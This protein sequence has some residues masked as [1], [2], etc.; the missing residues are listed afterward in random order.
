MILCD[1]V[2]AFRDVM[3]HYLECQNISRPRG[4]RRFSS[5]CAHLKLFHR[6]FIDSLKEIV[7]LRHLNG[8]FF[9][10]NG[11]PPSYLLYDKNFFEFTLHSNQKLAS[12]PWK[13]F[14]PFSYFL[15]PSFQPRLF[16]ISRNDKECIQIIDRYKHFLSAVFANCKLSYTIVHTLMTI[17]MLTRRFACKRNKL[18]QI[19][20]F[21]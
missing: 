5:T 17:F 20:A 4:L 9:N 10:T 21:T 12:L 15:F 14:F 19:L 6:F 2:E 1:V 7:D 3:L 18:Q 13:S 11:I 16:R 8:N